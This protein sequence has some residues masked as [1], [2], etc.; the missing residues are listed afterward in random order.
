M[1]LQS[2]Y[3]GHWNI[4]PVLMLRGFLKDKP[5]AA[6]TASGAINGDAI[7]VSKFCA[8]LPDPTELDA[9]CV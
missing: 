3:V 6:N 1:R 9:I 4:F 7:D 8:E 5:L 2:I